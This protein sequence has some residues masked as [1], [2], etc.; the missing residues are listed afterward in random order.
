MK[1][2]LENGSWESVPIPVCPDCFKERMQ[3]LADTIE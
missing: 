2:K 3:K 1:I